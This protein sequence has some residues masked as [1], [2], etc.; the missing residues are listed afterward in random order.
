MCSYLIFIKSKLTNI[1]LVANSVALLNMF[2]PMASPERAT[3]LIAGAVISLSGAVSRKKLPDVK[4]SASHPCVD[5]LQPGKPAG[6][7]EMSLD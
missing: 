4:L 7:V 3:N 5:S 1:L 6:R 2:I